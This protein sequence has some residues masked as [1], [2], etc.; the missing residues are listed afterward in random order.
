MSGKNYQCGSL[1]RKWDL[2]IHSP[3]SVLNNQFQGSTTEEKWSNYISEIERISDVA[4]LGIT[5]YFSV[6]GYQRLLL[7]QASGQ[8]RNIDLLLPN[9]ELRLDLSTNEGHPVNIHVIFNPSIVQDLETRFFSQLKFTFQNTPYSATKR[10]LTSLGRVI[11]NDPNSSEE[12]QYKKGVEQFKVSNTEFFKIIQNDPML[13]ENSFIVVADRS[14]D[15]ASGVRDSSLRALREELYRR[16]DGIFSSTPSTCEYFLGRGADTAETVIQKYGSLKPCLHGSDA[17][18]I[19]T[20]CRP[21]QNRFTWIKADPTFEGL[22]QVIFEPKDRVRIQE[23][24]PQD[25]FKRPYFSRFRIGAGPVFVGSQLQYDN[26]D[27]LLNPNLVS[28]IGGRGSGKSVLLGSLKK[29]FFKDQSSNPDDK[30][31]EI[32]TSDFHATFTKTDGVSEEYHI[33]DEN[34]LEY[35]HVSQGEVKLIVQKPELLDQQIKTLL[36][37]TEPGASLFRS[38]ELKA[39]LNRVSEIKNYFREKD[40]SGRYIN[41]KPYQ[42]GLKKKYTDLIATITTDSNKELIQK[43]RENASQLS[44][45][46]ILKKDLEETESELGASKLSLSKR[47]SSLNNRIAKDDDKIPDVNFDEQ[48][49]KINQLISNIAQTRRS[50][51]NENAKIGEDF[52]AAGIDGDLTTLL[53]K[54][55]Q[56]QGQIQIHNEKIAEIEERSEELKELFLKL[57]DHSR[58]VQLRLG[59]Y[60]TQLQS[61]WNQ[62]KGGKEGWSEDQKKLAQTLTAD[63][64]IRGEIVFD[65]AAFYKQISETINKQKFKATREETVDDRIKH[66][67][68]VTDK[69]TY[70]QGISGELIFDIGERKINLQAVLDADVFT[71]DGDRIFLQALFD[72]EAVA[73]YL[74]VQCQLRYKNKAP[75]QLSVGQRGTFFVC[76]KLATDTF[77]LPFVFD[78]PEDDLDNAFIMNQLVPLFREIKKYRQVIVV[79]H[80]ANLVVNADAEQVIV[81]ENEGEK[82]DYF[83]GALE[84]SK[85]SNPTSDGVRESVCDILEGGK[86]AFR[87]REQKYRLSR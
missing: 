36:G 68:G 23:K 25:E 19:E 49:S 73:K 45:L 43:Y 14:G 41:E 48:I 1:W 85:T 31:G 16:V 74:K 40:E 35:L 59:E 66:F 44:N 62:I 33:Q 24:N 3:A 55:E 72:P 63:I 2:H 75:N 70:F 20:L 29:T 56:Y 12:A 38:S 84:N 65:L 39:Y 67:I 8:L 77:G 52:K 86:N 34:N 11:L 76:L 57:A 10:E 53:E 26:S 69:D 15:G 13:N 30:S 83:A 78:Q 7:A 17:H 60:V 80:N 58:N 50:L 5:D 51:S 32:S 64:E 46:L 54:V 4:V 27:I 47:I 22:R 42:E 21:N 37:I 79:T 81:A 9:V 71:K 6:D 82:M 18:T 87:S 28:I 61:R